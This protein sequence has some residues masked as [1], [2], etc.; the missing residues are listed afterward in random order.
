M[1]RDC[2]AEILHRQRP[3]GRVTW[4]NLVGSHICVT[5]VTYFNRAYNAK[6]LGGDGGY[7]H[8]ENINCIAPKFYIGKGQLDA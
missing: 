3:V 2:R 6:V 8:Y 1:T 4:T 7:M 5:S